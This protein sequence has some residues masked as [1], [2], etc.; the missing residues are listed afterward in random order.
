MLNCLLR[1]QYGAGTPRVQ[2]ALRACRRLSTL[3]DGFC[4]R[5]R[6]ISHQ[7]AEVIITIRDHKNNSTVTLFRFFR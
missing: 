2:T 7:I 5:L 4:F 3:P 1:F 6:Q